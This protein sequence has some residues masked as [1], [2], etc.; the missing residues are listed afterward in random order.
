MVLGSAARILHTYLLVRPHTC[1]CMFSSCAHSASPRAVFCALRAALRASGKHLGASTRRTVP[2]LARALR[3]SP[4]APAAAATGAGP[5]LVT[6]GADSFL[7]GTSSVYV[8]EMYRAW[9]ADPSR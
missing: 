9:K 8:E 5:S 6:L 4:F 2:V 7:S 1:E 3:T